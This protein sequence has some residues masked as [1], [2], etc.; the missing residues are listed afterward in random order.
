MSLERLFV[1]GGP[2]PPTLEALLGK[3]RLVISWHGDRVFEKI[4]FLSFAAPFSFA[5][6]GHPP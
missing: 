2:I 4:F 1:P 5:L 6:F 3:F